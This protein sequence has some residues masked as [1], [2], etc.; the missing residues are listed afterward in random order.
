[1]HNDSKRGP[2]GMKKLAGPESA[3]TTR[4]GVKRRDFLNGMLIGASGIFLGSSAIG[5]S[6]DPAVAKLP[7]G[8]D[9]VH[10]YE[11][12]HQIRDGKMWDIPAASGDLYDCI[13]IGS[14]ISGLVSAWKLTKRGVTNLLILEKDAIGGMSQQDGDP[15]HPFAQ[16]AAYTVYPYNDNLIEIYTDLG[17]VTG[18]DMDGYPIVDEKYIIGEPANNVMMGGKI[19][20]DGWQAGLDSLPLPANVITDLKACVDDMKAWYDYVGMDGLYAFDTPSDAS[21]ADADVRALDNLTFLDYVKSKG[22]DPAVSE[23]FDRY[24]RSALGATH[25]TVSAWAVLNFMGSEFQPAMSQPGGNAYLAKGLA[26]KVGESKIKTGAVVIRAKTEGMEV[27]VTYL[28][29]G[30]ATTI[31]AKTA[32]CAA[33]L[34]IARHLLPDL[35]AAGRMEGKDFMYTPYIVA[36]VHVNKTPAGLAYDNWAHGDYIFTDVIVADWAGQ[37]DPKS[38]SL[39]RPNVLSIYTPLFGPTARTDLQTKPFEEYEK[40]ILDDLERLIPG[41]GKTV[42]Q[43]DIYRWGHAML[44]ATKGFIFSKSRVDSQKPIGLISFACHDVDGLPAFENAVGAAFRAQ[45]EVAMVLGL[46]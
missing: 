6:D 18:V 26:A 10:E 19:I 17:V 13:I 40:L 16:A 44:S 21:T 36:Q 9:K 3:T 45:E 11:I 30:A 4:G 23:F 20:D 42:T 29:N 2:G 32:I 33:P 41:I 37:S 1:M 15:A 22:W 12:C 24:I 46:P 27:H 43:F 28:E 14:G 34:Y 38:A 8:N 25:D 31:R 5:C 35:A 39:D 7:L